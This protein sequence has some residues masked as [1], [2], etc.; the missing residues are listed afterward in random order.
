MKCA[1]C[2]TELW[3]SPS[4][5]PVCGASTGLT[6]P[7]ARQA[8]GSQLSVPAAPDPSLAQP[9]FNAA[10]LIDP[11]LL[12]GSLAA[13]PSG[14]LN[15]ADLIDQP[16]IEGAEETQQPGMLNAADLFDP[17]VLADLSL[18]GSRENLPRSRESI[19]T[20]WEAFATDEESEEQDDLFDDAPTTSPTRGPL[21]PPLFTLSALPAT[22]PPQRT[23]SRPPPAASPFLPPGPA[24]SADPLNLPGQPGRSSRRGWHV[25]S[26]PPSAPGPAGGSTAFPPFGP[27][28]GAM[29]SQMLITAVPDNSRPPAPS[30]HSFLGTLGGAF[31]LLL[32]IAIIGIAVLFAL[33]HYRQLQALEPQPGTSDA[34]PLPTVAPQAG[35]KIDTDPGLNFSLQYPDSWQAQQDTDKSDAQYRGDLFRAGPSAAL[36]VG[37]SPQYANWNPA[38]I[39]DY[40][41]QQTFPIP[42]VANYQ[43][44]VPA[45]P[46]IHIANLDWTVEDADLTLT[47][48]LSLHLTSLAIIHNGRGYTIF[49]FANQ[50]I[51]SA[52]TTQYFEPMLLSFRFLNG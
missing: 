17:R 13:Q 21:T 45:S 51:F 49:Y 34:A 2:T 32:V 15:L 41:L 37:S 44:S 7:F 20:R 47:D 5:C 12:N 36:E 46:T 1:N 6:G 35:Y 27:P 39:D 50:Q 43:I 3:G 4:I 30:G 52:Y 40:I 22:P 16:A 9:F 8:T 48:G 11:M 42:N 31:A 18:P 23:P 19:P 10:D 33:N 38:Q 25:V 14:T 24:A 29:P 28:A 26:N